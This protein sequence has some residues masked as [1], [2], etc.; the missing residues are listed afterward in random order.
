MKGM[1]VMDFTKGFGKASKE[2][3]T[4]IE[5]GK[6]KYREDIYEGIENFQE[7]YNRLFSGEKRGKLVLKVIE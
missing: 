4:W 1:V 3:A 5:E 7:T 6:I 2:M